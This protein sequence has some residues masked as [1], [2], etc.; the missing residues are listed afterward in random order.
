MFTLS[1]PHHSIAD[2]PPPTR[3]HGTIMPSATNL[4]YVSSGHSFS[5]RT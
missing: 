4:L 5:I 3:I 2:L 1:P